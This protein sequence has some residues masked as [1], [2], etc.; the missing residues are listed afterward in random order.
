MKVEKDKFV[1]VARR[2]LKE[3]LSTN[4]ITL[5]TYRKDIVTAFNSFNSYIKERYNGWSK[6]D[7]TKIV[8]PT[9]ASVHEKF[10]NCISRLSWQYP[11]SDPND[12]FAQLDLDSVTYKPP[13]KQ[14]SIESVIPL[15]NTS[16][17]H[18]KLK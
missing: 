4:P 18:N 13:I 10:D 2:I 12:K 15:P 5:E 3:N 17:S 16:A 1:E 6:A 8:D 14:G 7:R 9:V 11:A